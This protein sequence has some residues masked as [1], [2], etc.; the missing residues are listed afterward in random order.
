MH[1]NSLSFTCRKNNT[2]NL[3]KKKKSVN[4]NSFI[5]NFKLNDFIFSVLN[6]SYLKENNSFNFKSIKVL[7]SISSTK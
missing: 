5:L 7:N 1:I 2:M 4:I 3:Y 6:K